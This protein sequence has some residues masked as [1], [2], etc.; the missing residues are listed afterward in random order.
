MKNQNIQMILEEVASF[1]TRPGKAISLL[2]KSR[3]ARSEFSAQLLLKREKTS[4]LKRVATGLLKP[5]SIELLEADLS[6][7][8]P[9]EPIPGYSLGL[10]AYQA[11]MEYHGGR[12]FTE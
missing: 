6:D 7:I 3:Y 2:E 11:E 10:A 9:V 8:P 4:F 12:R 5:K 1:Y